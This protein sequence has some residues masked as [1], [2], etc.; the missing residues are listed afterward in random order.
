MKL[1]KMRTVADV[2]AEVE[3]L[4]QVTGD[5]EYAHSLEDALLVAVLDAIASGDHVDD[6]AAL[7]AAALKVAEVDFPRYCA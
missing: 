6:P 5:F 2:E 7:A 4:R 3:T 1:G